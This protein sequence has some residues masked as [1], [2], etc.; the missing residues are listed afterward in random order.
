MTECAALERAQGQ[1]AHP[2]LTTRLLDAKYHVLL[3]SAEYVGS[4]V[5][6]SR[7]NALLRPAAAYHAFRLE[8][9]RGMTPADIAGFPLFNA[10][11]PRSVAACVDA[12]H[13]R[14]TQLR[15]GYGVPGATAAM[16]RLDDLRT[17]LDGDIDAAIAYGLHEYLD[18]L[19]CRLNA[20]S[21]DIGRDLL[22]RGVARAG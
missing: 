10:Q 18:D 2:Y 3:P 20:L 21:S 7:W 9:P 11:F 22:G 16:G 5:D 12:I 6:V 8:H 17:L 4:P 15:S 19:Q 1:R 14:L 13:E